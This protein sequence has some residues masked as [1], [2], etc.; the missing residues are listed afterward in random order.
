MERLRVET[1]RLRISS[2]SI[3][4]ADSAGVEHMRTQAETLTA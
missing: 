2:I 4:L 1:V 3:N